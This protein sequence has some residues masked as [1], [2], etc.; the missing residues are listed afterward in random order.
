ML[1]FAPPIAAP[2]MRLRKPPFF[3]SGLVV[4]TGRAVQFRLTR[5][6]PPEPPLLVS[7][8]EGADLVSVTLPSDT[9]AEPPPDGGDDGG[10]GTAGAAAGLLGFV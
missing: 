10:G 6:I 9:G 7:E 4:S 2:A 1:P 8:T 5:S 3:S